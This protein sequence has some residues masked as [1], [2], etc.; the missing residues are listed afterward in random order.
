MKLS[1][2]GQKVLE[3]PIIFIGNPRSGTSII[4]EIV[5]RHKDLA[6]PSQY[7]NKYANNPRANYIRRVFDNPVWRVHGQKNQLNKVSPINGLIFLPVEGYPMW[8]TIIEKGLNFSRSFFKDVSP[9]RE[10]ADFMRHYFSQMVRKQGKKRL[11]FKITGP[12]RIEFLSGIFPNAIFVRIHRNPVPTVSSLMKIGFWEDRGKYQ[13]WWKGPYSEEEMAWA[14]ANKGNPI[15]LTAFQIKKIVDVTDYEIEKIKP[16][17]L[18]VH[19][20]D[21]VSSPEE[22]IQKILTFCDLSKDRACF[23]YFKKNKIFNQNKKDEDYF[24]QDALKSIYEIWENA[25]SLISG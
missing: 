21:F 1:K 14:E 17:V 9:S 5:M 22:I 11:C 25:S 13:L 15:A 3:R 6:F 16:E 7:Q 20:E 24:D 4:S 18:D 8:E 23:N 19:Y 2:R 10:S 12:S